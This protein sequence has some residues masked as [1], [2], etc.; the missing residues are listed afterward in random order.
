MKRKTKY[1]W[2]LIVVWTGILLVCIATWVSF[3]IWINSAP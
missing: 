2:F 3:G 1:E